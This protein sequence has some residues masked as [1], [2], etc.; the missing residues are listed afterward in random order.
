MPNSLRLR[1]LDW[2]AVAVAVVFFL[3][4]WPGVHGPFVFDDFPNLGALSKVGQ[5]DS[6][7]RLGA[8]LSESR[9]FPGRPL[10]MLSFLAQRGAWPDDP[11]PF[12]VANLVLHGLNALAFFA[13]A[14]MLA[15]R[16]PGVGERARTVAALAATAWLVAPMQLTTVFLVVQRMTLLSTLFVFLG[17][18]AYLRG[19]TAPHL[20]GRARAVWMGLGIGVGTALAVLC[21]ENGALL[22]LLAWVLDATL[23]R[24]HIEALPAPLKRWRQVLLF[25]A[26]A[27]IVVFLLWHTLDWNRPLV[28]RDFTVHERLLTEP[29]VL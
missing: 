27:A 13:L 2:L 28:G 26:I 15:R 24:A 29:R 11:M 1:H 6:W 21:K 16:V 18:L 19:T 4:A 8:Y 5:I 17:L 3:L 22:P 10:A 12:K 23:L 25:P 9:F 20:S 14:W 7:Q